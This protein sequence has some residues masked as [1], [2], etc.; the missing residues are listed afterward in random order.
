MKRHQS[1]HRQCLN[2]TDSRRR[3]LNHRT[4]YKSDKESK[5]RIFGIQNKLLE[6]LRIFQRCHSSTHGIQSQ[7]QHSKSKNDLS[8]VTDIFLLGVKHHG[9]TDT[10][11]KRCNTGYVQRNDDTGDSR[12]NVR[13]HDN[14]GSL[15]QIHNS[16]ID[17]AHDHNRCRRRRLNDNGYQHTKQKSDHPVT[18]EFLQQVFHL[19]SCCK[20]KSLS[21]VAHTEQKKAKSP[22]QQYNVVNSHF[23]LLLFSYVIFL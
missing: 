12:T 9:S 16:G 23:R 22:K 2:D 4:E 17:K 20:L 7:K 6:Y 14:A 15:C 11:T 3:T 8:G 13:T 10:D 5:K 1:L 21:H 19:W 18:G